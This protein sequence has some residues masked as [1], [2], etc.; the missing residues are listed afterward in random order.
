[1]RVIIGRL[2][3]CAT[4]VTGYVGEY[5]CSRRKGNLLLSYLGRIGAG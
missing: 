1:M 3:I 5:F 4:V 2:R